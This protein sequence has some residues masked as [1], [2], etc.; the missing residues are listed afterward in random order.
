MNDQQ[1]RQLVDQLVSLATDPNTGAWS[2]RLYVTTAL[3]LEAELGSLGKDSLTAA[4]AR[5]KSRDR[6]TEPAN[7]RALLDSWLA[8]ASRLESNRRSNG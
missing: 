1:K 7:F 2:A 4:A 3:W 5:I 8:P 6:S